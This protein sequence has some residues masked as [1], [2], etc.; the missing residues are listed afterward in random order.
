M[1]SVLVG[2]LAARRGQAVVVTLVA[3]L[4]SAAVTA[5]PWYA[6]KAT[7][8]VGVA[9]VSSAPVEQRLVSVSW[10]AGWRGTDGV[11]SEAAMK[12]AR[13]DF[14]PPGFTT[15]DGAFA[16]GG[17][18][19]VG[20]TG[21]AAV[22][23]VA[24][25]ADVF[26]H[27]TVTG[28]RPSAA[29]E[30][31][32][33]AAFAS[34][35]SLRVGDEVQLT[36]GKKPSRARLV[37]VYRVIDPS[38]PYWADGYLVGLGSDDRSK[39]ATVFTVPATMSDWEQT[40]YSY[41][42]LASPRAFAT[43]DVEDLSANVNASLAALGQQG[44]STTGSS[45]DGLL[46]RIA[47]DRRTVLAGVGVGV[48]VLLLFTWFAL[49]V[50]VREA[51]VQV[52]GDVGWWR[53]HGAPSGRGWIL[54][55]GQSVAPLLA[56]AVIGTTLGFVV[57]RAVSGPIDGGG[58]R[59]ALLL[60][61]LLLGL[62]LAGGL[63][64]VVSAQVGTLFT[65]ARDL[66][67]RIPVRRT[68][69]RRSLVDLVL[70]ALAVY[71]V[72]QA[73]VVGRSVEG[74]P[75]LAP[76]L[77]AL[78][79]ALVTAWAV[80]PVANWLLLHARHAGRPA[81][82]L[83]AALTARRPETHRLFALVTVAI[84][85][86]T[87]AFVG[88]DTTSRSQWDRAALE[89]GADRVLT[90]DA[91]DPAQLLAAVRSAD[92]SG[93]NAMAVV[94]QP[95]RAGDP[96]VLAMDTSRLGVV[97]GWRKE[98]GGDVAQ[99]A[100]ALSPVAPRPVTL[101]TDR[102]VVDASGTDPAGAPVHLR[103]RLRTVK[104]GTPVDAVVGPLTG[105]RHQ[106]TADVDACAG[107]CRLVGVQALGGK[108]ADAASGDA[109]E[110]EA[111]GYVPPTAGSRVELYPSA[112]ADRSSLPAALLS[113]PTRWRP[114]LGPRDLGPAIAAGRG[115]LRLTLP[116]IPEGV[117]LNRNDWAFVADTPV[118]LPALIAGWSPD[119][120]DETRLV[121]LPGAAVP[122]QIVRSASLIPRHG[123]MGTIVDLSYAE[124]LVPFS[125]S[126]GQP[127]VWLAADA[128]SSI[129]SDLRAHG[130]APVREESLSDRLDELRAE[131]SAV[132]ERFQAA[133][134]LVGLLLAAGA[135][136]IDAA[137]E[138]P[139]RAVE[140]AALRTQGVDA[141]VVRAVGY[142][143]LGALVGTAALVGLAAGIGGAAIDRI[144]YPGF[145][146]GWSVLPTAD[147][148]VVPVL[149]AAVAAIALL[150]TVVVASGS[151]LVR[152]ARP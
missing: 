60:S 116:Q 135:V 89:V 26:D 12:Q 53:L 7:Q 48:V 81:M 25:R 109:G 147:A 19:R 69:W 142:G 5:A 11:T 63:V 150:G 54:V 45:L 20:S 50:V 117:S 114:G 80:P 113:E 94:D 16:Q 84:A 32:L 35:V 3:L 137:R 14:R 129:V 72:V 148:S 70:I 43:M 31:V 58:D 145:V 64:A 2:A 6:V 9:A 108:D 27:L 49:A 67:R 73:L 124:R 140:L 44:Y 4:A 22:V 57:G 141:K 55:L 56:G 104:D 8:Q 95:S 118:R 152:Q 51:A 76:G 97:T 15:I 132:G 120:T 128:P 30:I 41:D 133:V 13:K 18:R 88:W 71:G 121:P 17:V 101:T 106:Y 86:V 52:R 115:S 119:P 82:A 37:G 68:R 126:G 33:P 103:I 39:Q 93:T 28:S 59:T 83:I 42:L 40:T 62:T 91:D 146:D 90:V 66:L 131:G 24:Y 139:G 123:S 1:W 130:V 127:Q 74:L 23:K 100:A 87:T 10:L 36:G 138:R 98:Y 112:G 134:A 38:E 46:D 110:A 149:A 92:P 79:I 96:S 78:A 105:T 125:L 85:L 77:A 143:G 47:Q 21:T 65:P 144:L 34:E 99:V 75:L 29:G 151:A 122:A 102:L 111:L 61:L 136:L 107:G